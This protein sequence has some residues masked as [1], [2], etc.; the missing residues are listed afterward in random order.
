MDRVPQFKLSC[1]LVLTSRHVSC[2]IAC[3]DSIN[4]FITVSICIASVN[5]ILFLRARRQ[6][7]RTWAEVNGR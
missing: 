4:S 3:M 1:K 7:Q 5:Y 6:S 2:D